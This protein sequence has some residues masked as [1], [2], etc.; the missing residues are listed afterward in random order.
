MC[1]QPVLFSFCIVDPK[2]GDLEPDIAL[3]CEGFQRSYLGCQI[4][5]GGGTV[6]DSVHQL[7]KVPK[8]KIILIAPTSQ[9]TLK[10]NNF[11]D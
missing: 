8:E 9:K 2:Q 4:V 11:F 10:V 7:V 6:A 1:R 3:T 5:A